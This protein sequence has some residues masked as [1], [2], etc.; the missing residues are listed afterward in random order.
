MPAKNVKVQQR[1]DSWKV[2]WKEFDIP[3]RSDM[4][5]SKSI[6]DEEEAREFARLVEEEGGYPKARALLDHELGHLAEVYT[7]EFTANLASVVFD[8][9]LSDATKIRLLKLR[10]RNV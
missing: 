3:G 5:R 8:E 4:G 1:E 10:M 9:E 2:S 7:G 6:E